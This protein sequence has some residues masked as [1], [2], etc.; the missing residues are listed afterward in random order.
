MAKR[1]SVAEELWLFI[2]ENKAY[3][4]VPI[5]VTLLL[6]IALIALGSSASAPFIYT[7][8]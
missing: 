1:K 6:F 3:W 5:I 7:I 2:K 8:F 4:L